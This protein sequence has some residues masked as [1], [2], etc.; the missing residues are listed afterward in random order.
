MRF[1]GVSYSSTL[2]SPRTKTM[3]LS[4]IVWSRCAIVM[5]VQSSNFSLIKVYMLYSVTISMLAVASSNNITL[6]LRRIARQMQINCFSPL[7][8]FDPPSV[9]SMSS[10]EV[11]SGKIVVETLLVCLASSDESPACF[12][13]SII[14]KSVAFPSGSILNLSEPVKS[15]GSYGIIVIF[16]LT[17][18]SGTSAIF[19]P[20]IMIEPPSISTI[21]VSARLIV[22]LPAPVLPT[23]PILWPP[24]ISKDSPCKTSSV[25]GLYLRSTSLKCM[26]PTVGHSLFKK[27]VLGNIILSDDACFSYGISSIYKHLY[28]ETIDRSRSPI[29]YKRET[30]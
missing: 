21:L 25:F 27:V 13:K 30:R 4:I 11:S 17:L 1:V 14:S 8:K 29:L 3:S 12:N 6:F 7:L 9:I 10:T 20:S 28:T 16:S 18:S 23:M 24:L 22:L 2:P 19:N 26:V 15:V 5:T